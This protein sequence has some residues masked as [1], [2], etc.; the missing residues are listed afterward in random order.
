[1]PRD[2]SGTSSPPEASVGR[3][4]VRTHCEYVLEIEASS[5]EE[6][7]AKAEKIDTAEWDQSWAEMEAE[8]IGDDDTRGDE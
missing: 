5:A 6:A 7:L 8:P 1:M 3:Y 4:Q 2:T